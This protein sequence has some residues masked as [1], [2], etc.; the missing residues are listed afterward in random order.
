MRRV[1]YRP[2]ALA[3]GLTLLLAFGQFL[4]PVSF[5][6]SP[7]HYLPLHTILEM[8]SIT[9]SGMLFG[10]TW[11]MRGQDDNARRMLIGCGFLAVCLVDVAHTLSY[12]GMPDFVTPSGA[13]KAINFWLAGRYI[14]A[15]TLLAAAFLPLG[16]WSRRTC[17]LAVM[18]A[19][20]LV[21]AVYW[22]ELGLGRW[23]PH[24]FVAGQGLT[25]FKI[26]AEYLVAWL[27]A[28]AALRLTL[29]SRQSPSA[30][31]QWLAA[32][33]WIQGLAE[34][35]FTLYTDVTDIFNLLGHTYKAISYLMIYSAIFVC[36]VLAPYREL[37]YERSWLR[38][39]LATIP[40]PVWLKNQEGVYL[41]CNRAFE[42]LFGKTHGQIVGHTDVDITS[43]DAAAQFRQ[44]DLQVLH[45]HAP[46][47]VEEWVSSPG[48]G[49][50][51]LETTK[52]PM[53]LPSGELIGVLG[54]AHDI[55]EKAAT[56]ESLQ[57]AATTFESQEGIFITNAEAIIL[58]A[59][60]AFCRISGY[61]SA[62]LEGHTP[63]MLKSGR[64]DAAFYAAMVQS[65][66]QTGAWHGEVWNRHKDGHD[67]LVL[68]TITSVKGKD[69]QITHYVAN[70]IDIT[71]R[72]QDEQEL[73]TYRNHLEER[74]AERT[75]ALVVALEQAEAANRA[76]SVFLSNMSHELRTPLN[77]VIGFSQLMA[78]SAHLDE[79]EKRN[80]A[81]INRSGNHLLTLINDVLELSKIEAGHVHLSEAATDVA[82]LAREVADMLRPRA[83][84]G[85]LTLN[86]TLGPLPGRV[87]VDTVKLRQILLN[88]LSNAVKFTRSGQVGLSVAS[89]GQLAG[90]ARIEWVVSDTGVGIAQA[91]QQKIFEPFV[92]MVTHATAA[93]TGLGLTIT[94]QYLHMLNSELCVESTPGVGSVFRFSLLLAL[95]EPSVATQ[96]PAPPGDHALQVAPGAQGKRILVVED[97]DDA[98]HLLVQLLTPLGFVVEQAADGSEAVAQVADAAPDLVIMDW[99]MPKMDGLEATRQ[100][101]ALPLT[102]QPKILMLTA[103][104][105]E[106]QRVTALQAGIDDFLRKPLQESQL[107]A[108]L[109]SLLNL[110]LPH[111]TCAPAPTPAP[112]QTP[113]KDALASMPDALRAE[114]CQAV[115]A[116][117]LGKMRVLLDQLALSHP[118]LA[119]QLGQMAGQLQY[120]ELWTLL[121]SR[122]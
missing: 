121:S 17:Y 42:Q 98:R 50:R 53:H 103:S 27:Y 28:L 82:E 16:R 68:L 110:R 43:A 77:A 32:A 122:A 63:A 96:A 8:L 41:S 120:R 116:L 115:H 44:H 70:L 89:Q 74:V 21:A 102:Q 52:T 113:D 24:T 19:L 67:Y 13:E 2:A 119:G 9:I 61:A 76:K 15:L 84:Q 35:F 90:M 71:R 79:Q 108:A 72:K 97:H 99:R 118:A 33:A 48:Q 47:T 94:R 37:A 114:L 51:M 1:D 5:F 4:P 117:N 3:A 64:H 109:E 81:I 75:H 93:G 49:Q 31:W 29:H 46:L 38:T 58:R 105:F 11:S 69:A 18:L 65:I 85:G 20:L 14:S 83:E 22:L 6:A 88:L 86:L 55:T 100:I 80:L 59:N 34:M 36:G 45:S 10:L 92:Q 107:L 57:V 91:D 78:H 7:I 60:H 62:E 66:T 111:E 30:D 95:A 40:D 101:R 12:V 56:E 73:A 54:M 112:G 87:R 104:A 26:G 106:E 39:L 25:D 23:L